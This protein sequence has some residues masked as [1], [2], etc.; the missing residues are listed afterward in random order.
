MIRGKVQV[1]PPDALRKVPRRV[2]IETKRILATEAR[3]MTGYTRTTL[4]SGPRPSMLG[5]RTGNLRSQ[6]KPLPVTERSGVIESGMGFG[7]EYARPH[8]GPM[9]QVTTIRAKTGKFLAIPMDAAKTPAGVAR[10]APRSGVW[11]ETF[12]RRTDKGNLIL[13]GKRVAQKGAHA[14]QTRGGITPL[15]LMVK[16]VKIKS[17]VH[18]EE[19]LAWEKPKLI[20]AFRNIGIRLT[21]G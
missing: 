19:I 13:F 16:Q 17:R 7:T 18:P 14:G 4:M 21:G 1:Q 15:F 9:G 2:M 10:G 3:L 20:A 12:F 6:T 11:G 8:V 5:V